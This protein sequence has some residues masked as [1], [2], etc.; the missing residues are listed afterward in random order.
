MTC[1]DWEIP[2]ILSAS[3][4]DAARVL[5]EYFTHKLPSG[6]GPLYVGCM[7]ERY[8]G[9]GD[10]ERVRNVLTAE[11][12]VA[13]SMLG[14]TIGGRAA[15]RLL[16]SDARHISTLLQ[17]IPWNIDL[18][19]A[20]STDIGPESPAWELWS[21]VAECFPEGDTSASKVL[22]RKRPRLVPV[23]DP[24]VLAALGHE[25]DYWAALRHFL[26]RDGHAASKWLQLVRSTAGVG[27]D[28]SEIRVFDV[29][30]W[31]TKESQ[32]LAAE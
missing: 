26:F 19:D 8:A 25:G 21:L 13:A 2:A 32:Q 6:A 14:V 11:D 17:S 23:E 24:G 22:A 15:L 12:V 9:G 3:V 16:G 29:L 5:T 28:I 4:P 18:V 1:L 7:F 31:M 20:G 10:N 30:T 27:E